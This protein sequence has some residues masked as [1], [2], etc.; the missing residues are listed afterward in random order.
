M[1]IHNTINPNTLCR[2]SFCASSVSDAPKR[3][4]ENIPYT[5]DLREISELLPQLREDEIADLFVQ[6]GEGETCLN[7]LGFHKK[8]SNKAVYTFD[9]RGVVEAASALFATDLE[10]KAK[11][12]EAFASPPAHVE[13]AA[14]WDNTPSVSGHGKNLFGDN[15]CL[16]VGQ[17]HLSV[18]VV[19]ATEENL[20]YYGAVLIKP[21]E[22]FTFP[23]D[24]FWL[25][26]LFAGDKHVPDY[27]MTERGG[28]FWL[29]IHDDQPHINFPVGDGGGSYPL[30]RWSSSE[31]THLH[32]TS[33]KIPEGH[34]LYVR[35]GA[36][37][38]GACLSG[39]FI[40]G[41]K[42]PEQSL[43]VHMKASR[44]NPVLTEV[45]FS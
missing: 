3:S 35:K 17:D 22:T 7:T 18:P 40:E 8:V 38:S 21:G 23:D 42:T 29:E 14:E 32:I 45:C 34:G 30:G 11:E 43:T 16:Y 19:E 33:F 13:L 20:A 39:H 28:G 4:F 6:R 27:L 2:S 44:E 10:S 12:K 25:W 24:E 15:G 31:K 1:T 41:Y 9:E 36:M 5:S 37:H 26:F